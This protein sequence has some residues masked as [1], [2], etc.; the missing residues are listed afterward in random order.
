MICSI[1]EKAYLRVIEECKANGDDFHRQICEDICVVIRRELDSHVKKTS[2]SG[3]PVEEFKAKKA[4]RDYT[5]L[6]IK[7][8]TEGCLSKLLLLFAHGNK[9][10]DFIGHEIATIFPNHNHAYSDW[11]R[12]YASEELVVSDNDF[13]S[14]S[15]HQISCTR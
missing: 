1:Y 7:A 14:L 12:V 6:V 3:E 9:L 10:Y 4:T 13:I 11:I 2:E 8:Y 5:D 15:E